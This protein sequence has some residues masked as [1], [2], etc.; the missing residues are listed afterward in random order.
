VHTVWSLHVR[1]EVMLAST[2]LHC[3]AADSHCV[4][5]T[6]VV[7]IDVAVGVLHLVSAL[8]IRSVCRSGAM[9]CHSSTLQ[10]VCSV[11][12]RFD[13][14]VAACVIHCVDE[15]SVTGLH[16][17]PLLDAEYVVPGMHAE[18][19]R[20]DAAVPVVDI[21]WPTG[22]VFQAVHEASPAVLVKRPSAQDEHIRSDETVAYAKMY[23]PAA[24]TLPTA[25]HAAPLMM[26]ENMLPAAHGEHCRLADAEPATD[27][28]A[29]T[30]HVLHGAHAS[31][32]RVALKCPVAQVVHV[33]SALSV[34]ALSMYCPGAHGSR[35]TVHAALLSLLENVAPS[36]QRLHVRSVVAEPPVSRPDPAG[37]VAHTLHAAIPVL[38]LK[39]P[40]AQS[41]HTRSDD[42]PG[43]TVSYVPA[44]HMVM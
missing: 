44:P 32:P 37:H 10:D 7:A 30:G 35:T 28:P 14:K 12:T 40:S 38:A 15:H 24:H 6:V 31:L 22:Q 19:T 5:V 42:V 27:M 2:E 43:A 39:Y 9:V 29:P 18:H 21:P 4:D 41:V 26:G 1:S 3:A 11:H 17:S 36:E 8:H 20:S 25:E 34:A 13:D 23:C 16:A 33:R